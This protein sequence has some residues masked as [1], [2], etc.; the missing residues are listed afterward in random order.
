MK[1]DGHHRVHRPEAVAGTKSNNYA[2]T[3]GEENP[4]CKACKRVPAEQNRR[5]MCTPCERTIA[6]GRPECARKGCDSFV[7]AEPDEYCPEHS[8]VRRT[9]TPLQAQVIQAMKNGNDAVG[10][11]Q[12]V[13]GAESRTLAASRLN[14]MTAD[15][16]FHRAMKDQMEDEGLTD[17]YLLQ[18]LKKN[19][20]AKR[21]VLGPDGEMR[22]LGDDARASNSALDMALKLKGSYPEKDKQ[23]H[24]KTQIN[25]VMMPPEKPMDLKTPVFTIKAKDE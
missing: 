20:E 14:R 2:G 10:A 19:I 12:M 6:D 1:K 9:L 16:K 22:D 18:R 23:D 3:H 5:M 24:S 7:D 8:E 13:T 21:I 25:V 4:L 15:P 11:V 17:S